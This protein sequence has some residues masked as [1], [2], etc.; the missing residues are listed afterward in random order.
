MFQI[1]KGGDHIPA[2][3][4]AVKPVVLSPAI[5]MFAEKDLNDL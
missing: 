3:D 5:E 4:H 1:R 2:S